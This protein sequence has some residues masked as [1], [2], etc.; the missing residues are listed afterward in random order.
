MTPKEDI[1]LFSF[2]SFEQLPPLGMLCIGPVK[3]LAVHN[4]SGNTEV[5]GHYQLCHA[6]KDC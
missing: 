3:G 2:R 1:V 6:A 5:K 4:A